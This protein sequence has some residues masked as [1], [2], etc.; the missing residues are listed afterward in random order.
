MAFPLYSMVE[1]IQLITPERH[2]TGNEGLV[3]QPRVGDM[4]CIVDILS[5]KE[6]EEAYIVENVDE[7]AFTIWLADFKHGEL[8]FISS[9]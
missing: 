9:P 8:R 2:V 7:S 1:V 6:N 4:A 3:R 5:D